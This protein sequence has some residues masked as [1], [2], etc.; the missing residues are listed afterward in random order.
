MLN[1]VTPPTPAATYAQTWN[2]RYSTQTQTRI[3]RT[4]KQR[5]DDQIQSQPA[6]KQQATRATIVQAVNTWKK[7]FPKIKKIADLPLVR[8]EKVPMSA[9]LIDVTIQRLLDL[10]WVCKII[11]DFS[12]FKIQ[13]IHVYEVTPGGDLEEEFGVGTMLYGCWDSQHTAVAMYIIAAM[14]LGE[15]IDHVELP[16]NLYPVA[17]K[18]DI[19]ENF[20]S[21]NSADGKSLL[22][23]IDI[24]MQMVLGSRVDG[25]QNPKWKEAALKQQYIEEADLF[26]TAEKFGNTY[27]PGAISRMQEIDHYS[28]DIIRK[29]CMYTTT[30]TVPRP[31]ASQEIEIMCDF[32]HNAKQSGIDYTDSQIVDLGNHLNQ[33]FGADFHESSAFW[34]KVRAAYVNWHTKTYRNIPA[35]LRPS[36][37]RMSKNKRYGGAFLIYQLSKTWSHPVPPLRSTADFIPANKDLY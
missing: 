12:P 1:Y 3:L 11:K 2:T 7:N 34:T 27:M 6:M 14:G 13:P 8:A 25:N 32:F 33:L 23:S 5:L 29:F 35:K 21:L 10:S 24:Y 15:N 9:I 36:N 31:I 26:V 37:A 20:V 4:L 19:R 16:A 22:D 28:S 30:I 17:S 18:K